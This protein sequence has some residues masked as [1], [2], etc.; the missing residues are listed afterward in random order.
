MKKTKLSCILVLLFLSISYSQAQNVNIPDANFKAALVANL[1]INTNMD[2]EIQISEAQSFT[3][4][5]NVFNLG[6]TDLTGIEA[7]TALGQ[8]YCSHNQLT[9]LNISSNTS[10]TE[11]YCSS[12]QLTNLDISSNTALTDLDCDHNQLTNLNLSTNTSLVTLTCSYNQLTALNISSNTMLAYFL[13]THNQL[14]NLD[15]SSNTAL[16]EF[17]CYNNQLTTLDAS[18]NSALTSFYCDTNQLVSLNIKNGN[19]LN[20]G[21]NFFS[22][23]NNP[24]LSCIQ[25]D[26]VAYS[27]ANWTNIDAVSSFSTD[28]STFNNINS[29]STESINFV[30]FP[31]PAKNS[32]NLSLDNITENFTIEIHNSI[33][34]LIS[35]KNYPPTSSLEMELN[36]TSGIYFVTLKANAKTAIIKVIKE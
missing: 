23:T 15:I 14:S 28:C 22:S 20:L 24:N 34:Q 2:S 8:L 29:I 13:C 16:I 12:N 35:S 10:L 19:N 5:I 31:N 4:A 7:F 26:S 36:G 1:S 3:G 25:V 33:G 21:S 30:A 18:Q 11:L 9:S 6:I 17:R 27:V 32:L